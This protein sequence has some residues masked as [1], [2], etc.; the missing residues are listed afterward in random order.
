[1]TICCHS[2]SKE[3]FQVYR[4]YNTT[5][6]PGPTVITYNYGGMTGNVFWHDPG[7]LLYTMA[8]AYP[9]LDTE[10]QTESN[11]TRN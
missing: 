8:L 9:Y 6:P 7:E 10:L 2:S 5:S 11:N 4:P 1:M 3:V